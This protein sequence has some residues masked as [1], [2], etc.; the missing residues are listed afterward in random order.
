VATSYAPA[1]LIDNADLHVFSHCGHWSQIE[2][3]AD[4]NRIVDNFARPS[5]A[6]RPSGRPEIGGSRERSNGD[7]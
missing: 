5:T 1:D 6:A 7:E 4:C 3:S 2:C